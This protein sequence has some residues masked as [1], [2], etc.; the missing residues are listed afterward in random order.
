MLDKKQPIV[1]KKGGHGDHGHH[2]GS[3]KVAFADFATAMMAFFMLMWLLGST[4][5]AQREG[6][7][8]YF[9]NPSGIQGP[10]GASTSMIKLG[11]AMDLTPGQTDK[12]QTGDQHDRNSAAANVEQPEVTDKEVE[13]AQ[14]TKRLDGLLSDIKAAMERSQSL[15]LF[16]DQLL[17]DITPEGLRVQIVDKENRPMFDAG[18]ANIKHYTAEMLFELAKFLDKVPNRISITGHTDATPLRRE[19]YTNWELSADRANTARRALIDGGLRPEKIA[20]V[21]GLADSIPFDKDDPY[22]PVNRRITIVVLN[23]EAEEELERKEAPPKYD[24]TEKANEDLDAAGEPFEMTP[25]P[26]AGRDAA[27]S[28]GGHDDHG[29]T[30]GHRPTPS[31]STSGH[32]PSPAPAASSPAAPPAPAP[33]LGPGGPAPIDFSKGTRIP[34]DPVPGAA[35]HDSAAAAQ[36][37]P[38]EPARQSGGE[39]GDKPP[40]ASALGIDFF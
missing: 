24:P 26:E 4:S 35:G 27:G 32:A 21:I 17:L 1:I 34:L 36:K 20:R 23:Q 9:K 12:Y 28:G 7:S 5:A 3:W 30:P 22:N 10:G 33:S 13:K 15:Q 38:P 6:I 2:G 11:G 37:P 29:G 31:A 16:K 40:P 39:S 25:L 8:D 19:D 18:S 14:E